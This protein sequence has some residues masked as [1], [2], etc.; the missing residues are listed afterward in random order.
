MAD[1][2]IKFIL[3]AVDNASASFSQAADNF[4]TSA[5]DIQENAKGVEAALAGIGLAAGAFLTLSAKSAMDQEQAITD[6]ARATATAGGG[7]DSA[8]ASIT[9]FNKEMEAHGFSTEQTTEA[10]T[11][12]VTKAGMDLPTAMSKAEDFMA[13]A[14]ERN[15]SYMRAIKLV[16]N[17]EQD[18]SVVFEGAASRRMDTLTSTEKLTITMMRVDN[19]MQ[20]IGEKLMPIVEQ[21]LVFVNS[22]LDGFNRLDPGMQNTLMVLGIIGAVI[23]TIIGAIAGLL[24][25]LTPVFASLSALGIS[26]GSVA[27]FIG[28]VIGAVQA[29]VSVIVGAVS[30]TAAA[31]VAILAIA[32]IAFTAFM[33]NW[34]G[35]QDLFM[36]ILNTLR[37]TFW[38]F[39]NDF[40]VVVTWIATAWTTFWNDLQTTAF[41]FGVSIGTAIKTFIDDVRTQF[42]QLVE[43]AKDWGADLV[44]NILQSIQDE[45]DKIASAAASVADAAMD[46]IGGASGLVSTGVRPL[47]EG[48]IITSPTLAVLG[49]GGE[50]EY[51]IPES[52]MKSWLGA[53]SGKTDIVLNVFGQSD[54]Y[55]TAKLTS[56]ML[57]DELGASNGDTMI[58][59]RV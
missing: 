15:L 48:G 53:S 28:G 47:A 4:S 52:K 50:N 27:G 29:I 18:S 39:A 36:G 46:L 38:Q 13:V 59:S 25:A 19:L 41:N 57:M 16:T 23:A 10:L 9:D 51:V 34:F 58:S 7:F 3:E 8:K 42:E 55:L 49:E 32:V 31:F 22:L 17:E 40:V 26:A 6:A 12:L 54:P 21:G 5:A 30:L 24:L 35:I 33:Q 1:E 43:D 45:A 20:S 56:R 44:N 2:T 11:L 37:D 14:Q